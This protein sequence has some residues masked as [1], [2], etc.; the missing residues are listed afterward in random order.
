MGVTVKKLGGM[1][2]GTVAPT[3]KAAGVTVTM[4]GPPSRRSRARNGR[5]ECGVSVKKFRGVEQ[6]TVA[7]TE[8]DAEVTVTMIGPCQED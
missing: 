4:I 8:K 7:P 5:G 3:E 2:Q 1:G 6:G